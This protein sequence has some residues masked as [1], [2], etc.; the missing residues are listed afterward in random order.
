MNIH[1]GTKPH[2]CSQ[3]DKA[4]A[5]TSDLTIHMRPHIGEQP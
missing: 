1:T 4:F 5:Y 3:C 2:Q